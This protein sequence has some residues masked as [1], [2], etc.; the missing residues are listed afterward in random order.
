VPEPQSLLV[1]KEKGKRRPC[2]LIS[3]EGAQTYRNT[4]GEIK[5]EG[6]RCANSKSDPP[7]A[8]EVPCLDKS[9]GIE[10]RKRARAKSTVFQGEE[11][12]SY[13]FTSK[14]S[15]GEGRLIQSKKKTGLGG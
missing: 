8:S 13:S 5:Q 3:K 7:T 9:L 1:L 4:L 11:R 14:G 6:R 15:S 2:L 10:G 12:S